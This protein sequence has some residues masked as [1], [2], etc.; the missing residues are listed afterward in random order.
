MRTYSIKKIVFA[1]ISACAFLTSHCLSA[2]VFVSKTGS[3][4]QLVGEILPGDEEKVRGILEHRKKRGSESASDSLIWLNSNGGDV[5]TAMK[6]GRLLRN[7][8][9]AGFLPGNGS[10]ISACVLIL[11]GTVN[12][13]MTEHP[14]GFTRIGIHRFYFGDL[15][16]NTTRAEITKRYNRT[17]QEI[18]AYLEEMN[19]APSLLGHME[20]VPPGEVK[21]LTLE[22]AKMYRLFGRDPVFE[23]QQVAELAARYGITSAEYR[24]RA[25]STEAK[26]QMPQSMSAKATNDWW[27]CRESVLLQIPLKVYAERQN[28]FYREIEKYT[29][30][31]DKTR[32]F[33]EIM[34]GRATRC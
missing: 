1:A 12:R 21:Y 27:A 29:Q 10:C 22:S 7:E 4:Y 23:E 19:V 26:C 17:K 34:G 11:A 3:G 30:A 13:Y 14:D 25:A 32:C 5:H 15:A 16:P 8:N 18:A 28:I 9:W 2:D 31:D 24:R 6:I 20:S 33:R